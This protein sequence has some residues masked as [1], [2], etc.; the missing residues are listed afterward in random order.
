MLTSTQIPV[1]NLQASINQ[2][3]AR[4]GFVNGLNP[5]VTGR[6]WYVNTNTETDASENKGPV[7]S[8]SNSGRSPLAPFATVERAFEFIDCYD[9]VVIE[10]VVREQLTAPLGVFDITLIGGANTPRQAT[11][12]G[13]PTGGGAT[14][15]APTSPVAATPLLT[16]REQGWT[17]INMFM[18]ADTDAA[19]VQCRTNEDATY[20]SAGH[21]AFYG[22]VFGGGLYG[23]QDVG[24][25]GFAQIKNSRF[26]N[27]TG[28]S[29]YAIRNTSTSIA[30]PL[31]WEVIGN[32]FRNNKNHILAPISQG[33]IRGNDFGIVGNTITTVIAL[34]LTGGLNNTVVENYFNRPLNTS[35]NATLYV[36]GTNDLWY[37][38]FGTDGVF[39]GVPD[40]S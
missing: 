28:S 22:M 17:L 37:Q 13:V 6:I 18:S 25:L 5:A 7:G 12:N 8:N 3:Y 24:G 29:A 35:P 40:N 10:G 16:L 1:A 26:Q 39:Y 32:L 11:N 36:G 38:N 27:F 9:I 34:S 31:Q 33:S 23:I 15:L 30:N 2:F 21:A 4:G 20:P 19:C 14:W